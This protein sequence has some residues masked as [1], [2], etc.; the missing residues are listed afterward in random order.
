MYTVPS[1][2]LCKGSHPNVKAPGCTNTFSKHKSLMFTEICRPANKYA[3]RTGTLFNL[4]P[5]DILHIIVIWLVGLEYRKNLNAAVSKVNILCSTI[6]RIDANQSWVHN[7]SF[8][9]LYNCHSTKYEWVDRYNIKCVW[10]RS[11]T[12]SNI[13]TAETSKSYQDISYSCIITVK[14]I[15]SCIYSRF[16]WMHTHWTWYPAITGMHYYHTC[17]SR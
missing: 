11:F 4:L 5:T 2:S 17:I 6:L 13:N 12:W 7:I 15:Y 1:F 9:N 8:R 16:L 3:I 14:L 10:G